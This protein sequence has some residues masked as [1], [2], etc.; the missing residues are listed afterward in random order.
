MN[1]VEISTKKVAKMNEKNSYR[2]A[3]LAMFNNNIAIWNSMKQH[4]DLMIETGAYVVILVPS[5][6]KIDRIQEKYNKYIVPFSAKKEFN[7][8][9]R[10][11]K[12]DVIWY[13]T[14]MSMLRYDC[15]HKHCKSLLWVQGDV[16]DESWMRNHSR[17]RK[18][19]LT[20][21]ERYAM[22]K[23]SGLI[24]VSESMRH[25]YENKYKRMLKKNAIIPC[26]SEFHDFEPQKERIPE[27][28]V[29]IG[30]LSK[31]Q[32]FEE[33]VEVYSDIRTASSVFHVI[34]LDTEKAENIVK[35]KMGDTK[36][37]FIYPITDRKRIPEVLSTFQ[38]GFLI[39]EESPVNYVSSPIKFL[40]YLS[41]GVDVIMT[42]AVPSYAKIVKNYNV[43]TIVDTSD[44]NGLHI[45]KY[46]SN[47]REVYKTVF[48]R[49]KF[50][51][52]YGDLL[53]SIFE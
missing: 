28:Y 8:I 43:G 51:Q 41:C 15:G 52:Y 9:I 50:V 30:G 18:L 4:I 42:N 19:I 44:L 48:K 47:A 21:I 37:V 17:I 33:I 14:A 36:N 24:Y 49:E 3:V 29:Y 13:P 45:N 5:G 1:C 16:P 23:A 27:S 12:I 31:W 26:I 22:K 7:S 34:T 53:N 38:F 32:C 25:F 20:A 10:E 11:K 6:G 35:E 40:E 39:R 46:S 2:I